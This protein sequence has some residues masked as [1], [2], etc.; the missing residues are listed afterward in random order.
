MLFPQPSSFGLSSIWYGNG[1]VSLVVIGGI[2]SLSLF[3]ILTIFIAVLWSVDAIALMTFVRSVILLVL[4]ALGLLV[5]IAQRY[6]PAS[7]LGVAIVTSKHQISQ[8]TSSSLLVAPVNQPKPPP[9]LL[10]FSKNCTSSWPR[11]LPFPADVED[12]CR[13]SWPTRVSI[14]VSS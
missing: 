11:T 12:S 2:C 1:F 5:S 3:T 8:Q 13:I 6:I 9:F 7:V 10:F 14:K 4:G